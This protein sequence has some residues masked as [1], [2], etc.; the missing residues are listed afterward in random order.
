MRDSQL[1]QSEREGVKERKKQEANGVKSEK[2][3]DSRKRT[4]H[5]V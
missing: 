4:W 2:D 5:V 3:E 1:R